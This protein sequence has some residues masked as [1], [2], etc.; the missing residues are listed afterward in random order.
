MHPALRS[1]LEKATQLD[2][3]DPQAHDNLGNA[4]YK[5]RRTEAAV[6]CYR[7]AIALAPDYAKALGNLAAA[8]VEQ[9]LNDEAL[10]C[11]EKALALAPGL[12]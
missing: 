10:A 3:A 2:A 12:A 5:L 6:A 8:L 1:P 11:A 9:D 4:L 7:K